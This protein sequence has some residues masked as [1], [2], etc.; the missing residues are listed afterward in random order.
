MSAIAAP[1]S[2]LVRTVSQHSEHSVTSNR[3][4]YLRS[5]SSSTLSPQRNKPR[6][7]LALYPR[8][9]TSSTFTSNSNCSSYH[10]SLL[11]GP[12]TSNRSDPGTRFHVSHTDHPIHPFLYEETDISTSES[13][14]PFV[15]ITVAKVRNADRLTALLRNVPVPS[16]TATD[17]T[18]LSWTQAAFAALVSDRGSAGA[19]ACLS[20]YLKPSDWEF[21]EEKARKYVKRK[22]DIRRWD[23][24]HPGPWDRSAVSTWNY[25]ENRET[26]V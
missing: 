26:T 9:H 6:L 20:S 17:G 12:Q 19:S 25:W 7:Y 1:S 8:G 15:R 22:R 16:A 14:I 11:V 23:R 3:P 13:H 10:F 4:S 21:V 5:F 18:C 24:E 2:P